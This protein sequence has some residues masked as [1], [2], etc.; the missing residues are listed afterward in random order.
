MSK[1]LFELIDIKLHSTFFMLLV[2][3][4]MLLLLGG[5]ISEGCAFNPKNPID[6]KID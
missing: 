6:L 5:I 4:P 3:N 1:Q 2:L